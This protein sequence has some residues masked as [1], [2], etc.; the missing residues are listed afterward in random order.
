M[1]LTGRT[2]CDRIVVFD[3]N[4]RQIGQL[5]Q[6][7]DLRRQRVHAVRHRRDASTSAR[8]FTLSAKSCGVLRP[9]LL[10]HRCK[11]TN[12][13][14]IST[15]LGRRPPGC[16]RWASSTS[17]GA[18]ANLVNMATA[19]LTLD[20]LADM[21]DQLAEHLPQ[22]SDPDMALN[23]LE[24]FVAAARNPLSHRLAVRA[25]PRSAAG[26]AANLRHQPAPERPADQRQRKLR[27]AADDRRAAGARARRW[28]P[29][30][31]PKW[32]PWPAT[33]PAVMAA[34]RRFKRRETLRICYGDII[35]GQ[36]LDTV[37]RQISYLADAIVEAAVLAARNK[38]AARRRRC[39]SPLSAPT[40]ASWCWPWASWAASS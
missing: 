8:R 9:E 1:Q 28:W 12:C 29:S 20:L 18:H 37:T 22:S 2:H 13:V 7:D 6:G 34:L 38:I 10:R 40:A 39:A 17:S 23:N 35:R 31:P 33:K 26:A 16:G 36:Q 30:L 4:R 3:G 21:C 24:R 11:S 25:R 19:G 27:P 32:R 14:V 15:T 5:L